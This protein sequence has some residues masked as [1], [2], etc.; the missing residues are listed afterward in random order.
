MSEIYK[1]KESNDKKVAI[2]Q[3]SL[4]KYIVEDTDIPGNYRCTARIFA[5]TMDSMN[6]EELIEDLSNRNSY[7]ISIVSHAIILLKEKLPSDE[8]DYDKM[9]EEVESLIEDD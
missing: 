9:L 6:W 8:F 5:L 7:F 4:E 2:V 3:H 1:I